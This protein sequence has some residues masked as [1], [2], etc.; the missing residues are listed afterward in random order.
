MIEVLQIDAL[1]RAE[2]FSLLN[3]IKDLVTCKDAFSEANEMLD[4][5]KTLAD[6]GITGS[7]RDNE[8][9]IVN[10]FYDFTPSDYDEPLLLAL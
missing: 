6:Y 3:R 2:L 10:I 7:K 9:E 1:H 5:M 8:A 4:E